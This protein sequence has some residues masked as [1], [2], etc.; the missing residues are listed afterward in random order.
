VFKIEM[1]R[2]FFEK[3]LEDTLR[4]IWK[5]VMTNELMRLYTWT[6]TPKPNS[7]KQKGL[8][9]RGSRLSSAVIE[10]VKHGDFVGTP[11]PKIEEV[12]KV[13]IRKA[14]DRLKPPI[15]ESH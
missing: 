11:V 13:Y 3:T 1:F 8:A 9:V 4:S 14:V 2:G 6:G 15:P 10:A 12:S 7:G 5:E